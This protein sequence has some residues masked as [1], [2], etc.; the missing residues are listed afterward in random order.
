MRYD[1]KSAPKGVIDVDFLVVG[2]GLAGLN[3]ALHLADHGRVLVVTKRD[4]EEGATGY[5]QGGIA[6]VTGPNDSIEMHLEDTLEAGAGLCHPKVAR[7]II[8]EGPEA[9]ARLTAL[10]VGFDRMP[11]SGTFHLTREG[12]HSASRI[13]HAQDLTGRAIQR[14]LQA[15]VCEQPS[16]V[17]WPHAM[18]VDLITRKDADQADKRCLGAYVLTALG[19]IRAVRARA[20]LVACGGAGKAYM[21]TSNPDV[22]TGDG[23]AVAYRA[24]A[25][26][27]N[28]EFFQFHPT[29][30]FHPQAKSFLISEALRGEGGTLRLDPDG[31]A[32]MAGKH[33]RGDLAPRDVVARAIDDAMKREGKAHAWLDMRHLPSDYLKERFPNIYEK[34]LGFGFDLTTE[35]LPVVPAAHYLCGGVCTDLEG[36]TVVKGLWCAGESA[37]TGLHG[38]NRLAS[39]SLLEAAVMSGR[40]AQAMVR[41]LQ[42][43]DAST[44]EDVA[45]WDFGE[46][47]DPDEMVVVAH[48]WD[49]LRRAMWSYVGIVR[50]DRRLERARARIRLLLEEIK[51]YY[52]DFRPTRDL[53]ELRNLATVASLVVDAA[54]ARRESR[55]LHYNLDCPNTD[56]NAARPIVWQRSWPDAAAAK[57][58]DDK[59]VKVADALPWENN[60]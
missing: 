31:P 52:W 37:H 56:P 43:N 42:E 35:P 18:V 46:A 6:S 25:Y 50:S 57:D 48:N 21:F 32:L 38:A 34:C 29:C 5:A 41:S 3:A 60:A 1:S 40:S 58:W 33:P 54:Q 13:L 17:V 19:E 9:V 22:A 28:M 49:E 53:L 26:V 24:G 23:V 16:V 47:T 39:N 7:S 30:L 27:S 14:A 15:R 11:G 36:Q 45:A 44:V 12:G 2:S 4:A 8:E 20:T 59:P 55:G 51:E 10:G